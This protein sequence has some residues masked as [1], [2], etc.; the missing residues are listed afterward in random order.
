MQST[1]ASARAKAGQVQSTIKRDARP[2]NERATR[3]QIPGLLRRWIGGVR[4]HARDAG[5]LRH[6]RA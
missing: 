1:Q 3:D 5:R 2:H 6:R 4:K